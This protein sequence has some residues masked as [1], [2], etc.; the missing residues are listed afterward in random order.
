[1]EYEFIRNDFLFVSANAYLN[2]IFNINIDYL[3]DTKY[4]RIYLH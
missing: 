1:M 3:F 2:K 4:F